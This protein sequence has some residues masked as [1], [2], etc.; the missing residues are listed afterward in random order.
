MNSS[1]PIADTAATKRPLRIVAL[2]DEPF[3]LEWMEMFL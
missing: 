2:D 3:V 1:A